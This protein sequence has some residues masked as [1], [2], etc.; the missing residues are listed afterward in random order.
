MSHDN[1]DDSLKR[2]TEVDKLLAKL[3]YIS[4]KIGGKVDENGI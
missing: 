2:M 1:E 3:K 4:F